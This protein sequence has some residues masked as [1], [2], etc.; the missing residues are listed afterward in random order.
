[1]SRRRETPVSCTWDDVLEVMFPRLTLLVEESRVEEVRAAVAGADLPA[2]VTVL[3][4]PLVPPGQVL[5]ANESELD[6]AFRE[7]V[8]RGLR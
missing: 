3:A 4:S 2:R 1:V 6:R 8:L 5:V 7:A